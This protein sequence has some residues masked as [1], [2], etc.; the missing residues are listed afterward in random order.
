MNIIKNGCDILSE[1]KYSCVGC[2]RSTGFED[3][4]CAK[5]SKLLPNHIPESQL[6]DYIIKLKRI[7]DAKNS[8]GPKRIK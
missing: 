2:G 7:K 5:C 4:V 3:T 8:R 6:Q 1:L